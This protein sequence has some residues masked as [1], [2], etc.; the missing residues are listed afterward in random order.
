MAATGSVGCA[1]TESQYCA[2]SESTSISDGSRVGW[3]FPISS[4]A[5]PSRLVRA[6]ATM[7]R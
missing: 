2:R 4:I 3:Y 1:P 5:R 6:S 7:I